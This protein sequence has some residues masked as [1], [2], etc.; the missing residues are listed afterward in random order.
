MIKI[1]RKFVFALLSTTLL[2]SCGGGGSTASVDDGP[3]AARKA[4]AE[5]TAVNNA[6][7]KA[8]QPFYWEIGDQTGALASG[9]VGNRSDGSQW[10]ATDIM[11]IASS[12]KWLYGAYAVEKLGGVLDATNDIPFLNFTSGYSNFSNSACQSTDTVAACLNGARNATEAA[13]A[14]FH[15]NAGH[16]QTHASTPVI[17]LGPK[18][19]ATL[20]TEIQRLLGADVAVQYTEPQLAGGGKMTPQSYASF[21]RKLLGPTPA[22]KLGGLL[23]AHAT[24]TRAST[25]CNASAPSVVPENWHYSLGHWVEDDPTTTPSSNFAYSS[26]GAF[27]FY[28]W[29]DFPKTLYGLLAREDIS[30]GGEGFSSGQCGRLIRLAWK[31]STQQ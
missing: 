21:L 9:S 5:A 10:K 7:C 1:S 17:G 20:A 4:A 22:L 11:S 25:S 13:N 28:P 29:V 24:C 6:L 26:G 8:V 15:Y 31:T 16:F 12:S 14:V 18:V 19:N 30:A 3:N 23:G 27:G 2:A